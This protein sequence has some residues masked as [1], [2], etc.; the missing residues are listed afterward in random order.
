MLSL[1]CGRLT[2]NPEVTVVNRRLHS[3]SEIAIVTSIT[4]SLQFSGLATI[5]L[6]SVLL[7]PRTP[8]LAN[9]RVAD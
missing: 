2:G 9:F 3:K 7:L 1:D 8:F 5:R 4:R 6:E